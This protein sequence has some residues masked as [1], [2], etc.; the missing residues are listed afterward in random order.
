MS[1]HPSLFSLFSLSLS[2]S[3]SLCLSVSLSVSL[4]LEAG[5][6]GEN[7]PVM[8]SVVESPLWADISGRPF[9]LLTVVAYTGAVV[10][11]GL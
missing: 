6:L 2:L 9:S 8:S 3:L 4:S 7:A 10:L 11:W 5:T 1:V